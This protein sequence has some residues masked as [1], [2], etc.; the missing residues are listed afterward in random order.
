M[1]TIS[2]FKKEKPSTGGFIRPIIKSDKPLNESV[3]HMTE[4]REAEILSEIKGEI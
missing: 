1:I 2:A 4:E 3:I